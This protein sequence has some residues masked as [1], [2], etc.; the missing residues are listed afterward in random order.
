LFAYRCSNAETI[1]RSSSVA[2]STKFSGVAPPPPPLL[3]AAAL[4]AAVIV[5]SIWMYALPLAANGRIATELRF[6]PI[7]IKRVGTRQ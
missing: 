7:A 2:N 6:S 4:S 5:P 1:V 3:A